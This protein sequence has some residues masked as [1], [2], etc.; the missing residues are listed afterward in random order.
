MSVGCDDGNFSFSKE[1]DLSL[2]AYLQA[3]KQIKISANR[4]K[5][6][7]CLSICLSLMV[8]DLKV[9]RCSLI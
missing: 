4:T 7:I 3:A 2:T 6:L 1:C 9:L 5:H 8:G